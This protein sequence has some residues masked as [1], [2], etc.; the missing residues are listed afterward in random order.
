MSATIND[1][2]I[3]LTSFL[4]ALFITIINR[5]ANWLVDIF[6]TMLKKGVEKVDINT[7][8]ING[9]KKKRKKKDRI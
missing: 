2:Q 3:L 5:F 4:T 6:K 8:I 7:S 1:F 9:T